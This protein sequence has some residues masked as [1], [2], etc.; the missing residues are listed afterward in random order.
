MGGGITIFWSHVMAIDNIY[1]SRLLRELQRS[2][3]TAVVRHDGLDISGDAFRASI[4]RFARVL[5][6]L[7][8][9]RGALL[10]MFAP[11]RPE[12]LAL[13]YA[14]HVLGAATVYFSAP[15][16]EAQRLALIERIAPDL[17]VVFPETARY[18]ADKADR[19]FA[20]VGFEKAG[21]IGR[22]DTLAA[23]ASAEPIPVAAEPNDLA[24]VS[25]SGGSTGVPKGSC[26]SFT[27]YTTMVSAPSPRD[28]VQLINGPLAYLSQVLVD[29]TLLG[30][31]R[32]VLRP[33]YEAVDT[34]STIEA[35]SVTD[36]FLVEPQLFNLMDDAALTFYDLS[37]LRCLTHIGA[38]APR[39]LRLRARERFGP[40]VGHVYGASEIGLVSV[41]AP[42]DH[43]LSRPGLFTSAGRVLPGVGVRLRRA[44]GHLADAGEA[45]IIEVHSPAMASG[46]RNNPGLTAEHFQ[47]G[48]YVTGDLGRFDRD[49]L[50]HILG[51]AGDIQEIDG[52]LVASTDIE[53]ALCGL[54][55]IRNAVVVRNPDAGLTIA[56]VIAWPGMP[57]GARECRKA[58]SDRFRDAVAGSLVVLAVDSIPLTEQGKPDRATI[59]QMAS[60]LRAA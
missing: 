35:E 51:R 9:G 7:G 31:G 41:L 55:A 34:L 28:R 54:P 43:D 56:A 25:S 39:T 18:L 42:A 10:G 22:L 36:L 24:V 2:G 29:I 59:A 52:I 32:V 21:S 45:G 30:G 27:R 33:A 58:V 49:A 44:D 47:D 46:Y 53:D 37:S 23:L 16:T 12:A 4:F 14:A 60:Y 20:T 50:L 38:S 19:R 13:R 48:W 11:N 8:I 15:A 6:D 1:I 57:V 26:R 3:R 17:L 5:R 40:I